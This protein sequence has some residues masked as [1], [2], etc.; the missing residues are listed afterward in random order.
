VTKAH[1]GHRLGLLVKSAMLE[2]LGTAEPEL[3]RI[4]TDNAAP[5][6]FMIAVNEALGYRLA[7]PDRQFY[8]LQ[9]T[10]PG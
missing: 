2:W 3:T 4:V 5:N 9:V 6:S 8:Q 7:P 10:D 1:R